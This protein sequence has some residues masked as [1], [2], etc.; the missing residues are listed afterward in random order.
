MAEQQQQEEMA[1]DSGYIIIW[2]DAHIGSKDNCR[3]M[4][5]EF[6]VGLVEAAAVPPLPYDPINDLI[7][8][9]REYSAPILFV[10]TQ[11]DALDLIEQNLAFKKVIFISSATLGKQIVPEII[12]KQFQIESY[13]VFCGNIE[14]NR[15][16]GEECINDGLDVQMF[17]HQKTLLIRLCRDMSKIL[18]KDG[19][20]LLN[21]NK[22]ESALKYFEFAYALADKAVEYDTP[23]DD[24][25]KHRPSTGYRQELDSLI[26]KAKQAM[27]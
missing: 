26:K 17:D 1:I 20:A 10:D 14:Q 7:C 3:T 9:V 5:K 8:A 13:Y 19:K 2:L 11:K 4:K 18:T 12:E 6:E 22:P 23:I 21:A 24:S 16:W 27:E 15:E 25:D